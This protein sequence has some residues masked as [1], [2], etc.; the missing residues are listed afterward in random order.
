MEEREMITLQLT[1]DEL[2]SIIQALQT[3]RDQ[4]AN[5]SKSCK[6]NIVQ[7]LADRIIEGDNQLIEKLESVLCEQV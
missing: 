6:L 4:Y 3:E 2:Q 1:E 5:D 7:Q